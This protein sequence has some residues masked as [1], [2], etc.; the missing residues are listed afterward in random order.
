MIMVTTTTPVLKGSSGEAV[1]LAQRSNAE[2]FASAISTGHVS[3]Q[4]CG[5]HAA[6][7]SSVLGFR[8][9]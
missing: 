3:A 9:S 8:W 7:A 1:V 2:A 6:P 4:Q 5:S